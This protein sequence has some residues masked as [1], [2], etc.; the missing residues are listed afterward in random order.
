MGNITT[1]YDVQTRYLMRDQVSGGAHRMSTEL[2]AAHGASESLKHSLL[3][4]AGAVGIGFGLHE[5]W[6]KAKEANME[7]LNLQ[8][9]VTGTHFAFT[10][11]GANVS[12]ADRMKQSIAVA[13]EMGE[14]L[15]GIARGLHLELDPVATIYTSMAASAGK[16]GMSQE[17]TLKLVQQLAAATR[18]YGSDA[19]L[20]AMTVSRALETGGI[21]GV[22]NFAKMLRQKL[23]L[24]EEGKNLAPAEMLRRLSGGLG[25]TIEAAQMMGGGLEGTMADIHREGDALVRTLTGPAF[26]SIAGMLKEWTEYSAK[27][28]EHIEAVAKEVAGSLVTGLTAVKDITVFIHDHWKA[29]A[30]MFVGMKIPGMVA[31]FSGG[32]AGGLGGGVGGAAMA[33]SAAGPW[34]AAIAASGAML[35]AV[36]IDAIQ[37]G[38]AQGTE[39]QRLSAS[40]GVG[41]SGGTI[42]AFIEHVEKYRTTHSEQ[43]ARLAKAFA[44]N[45]GISDLAS[46]ENAAGFWTDEQRARMGRAYGADMN[47]RW[48]NS[49]VDDLTRAIDNSKLTSL[50]QDFNQ[51][52]E[53]GGLDAVEDLQRR[54]PGVSLPAGTGKKGDIIVKEIKIEVISDDPD[55]FAFGLD[56]VVRTATQRG[57]ISPSQIGS[58]FGGNARSY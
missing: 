34:G 49:S 51:A 46:L 13:A 44:K 42:D 58:H 4:L 28:R 38:N 25:G 31:G 50:F 6:H 54:F 43:E 15:E 40:Y 18:V 2:H 3:H 55:R 36:V 19:Q 56:E 27:N 52:I 22:D 10:Q 35:A 14:K 24:K 37:R 45:Q 23:N 39:D 20:V 53:T 17:D 11:W 12:T 7:M 41:V 57:G 21:R 8:K 9:R 29:L 47:A 26:K 48:G 33:G 30:L 5:I 1:T 32:L 16:L